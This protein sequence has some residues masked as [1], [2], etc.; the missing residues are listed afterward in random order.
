MSGWVWPLQMNSLEVNN[1]SV[2]WKVFLNV[3]DDDRIAEVDRDAI[4]AH[5]CMY[6]VQISRPSYNLHVTQL[7]KIAE[8]VYCLKRIINQNFESILAYN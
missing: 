4:P 5:V 2:I 3:A 1:P 6:I 8:M 7:I